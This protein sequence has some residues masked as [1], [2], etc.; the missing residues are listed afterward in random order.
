M[1]ASWLASIAA[2][3]TGAAAK[4][5][6]VQRWVR[7]RKQSSKRRCRDLQVEGAGYAIVGE[8]VPLTFVVLAGG[9][10][11][12]G[13]LTVTAAYREG[14]GGP[15]LFTAPP[16]GQRG[17]GFFYGQAAVSAG[18]TRTWN[19]GR[20]WRIMCRGGALSRCGSAALSASLQESCAAKLLWLARFGR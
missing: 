20:D 2:T 5:L 16:A 10:L 8:R 3:P 19:A 6:R 1:G 9:A 18:P 11:A 13:A 4:T 12:G 17:R 14:F 7:I 15:Q